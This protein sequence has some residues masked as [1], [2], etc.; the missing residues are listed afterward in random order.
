MIRAPQLSKVVL[1]L[2]LASGLGSAEEPP[3]DPAQGERYDGRDKGPL[4]TVNEAL[5]VPRLILAPVRLALDA[6]AVPLQGLLTWE[7]RNRALGTLLRA[8]SSNDD[9]IGV[10]P[11]FFY[12]ISFTPIVGIRVFDKKLLGPNS[13][14]EV[15]VMIGGVDV[16]FS[17][18]SLRPT[19]ANRAAQTVVNLVYNRRNDQVFTGIGY[20]TD[21][22]RDDYEARYAIEALDGQVTET[23]ALAPGIFVDFLSDFGIR[24]FGDGIGTDGE[25][26]IN[27]VYC[28]RQLNGLC[29]PGSVDEVQVPGFHRG[30]QFFRAGADIRFD[31]R[32]NQYRPS[33]GGLLE[34]GA[35]WTHGIGE[36][37]S[38]YLRLHGGLSAVLDLFQRSRTLVARVEAH[39]LQP[40]NDTPTPFSELIILGGPD[41]FRGFRYGRF[42]NQSSLFAALEYRW[43][44]WMWMD[45]DLFG[46]YGG[47]FGRDFEGFSIARMLPDIGAGI[48]LRSSDAFFIRAHV[49]YGFGPDSGVQFSLSVNT[50]L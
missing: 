38:H 5:V 13:N 33:S 45:A 12:S 19:P 39:L 36:D 1:I 20:A 4:V 3:P 26:P 37:S 29:R 30:T 35:D 7:E 32:D 21:H 34:L 6:V 22:F 47:V 48:R 23:L 9:A 31:S 28:V 49:A 42:R 2:L 15:T 10:R 24:R 46:E 18:L 27:D 14:A 50:G 16:I 43:P 40:L 44:I 17:E 41:T 8:F 11:A 25:P